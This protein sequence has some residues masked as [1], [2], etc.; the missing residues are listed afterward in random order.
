MEPPCRR[1][2]RGSGQGRVVASKHPGFKEGDMVSGPFGWQ[3]YALSDSTSMIPVQRVQ[4]F[5]SIPITANLHAMGSGGATAFVGLYDLAKPC[6]G[7][8]VLVS[9]AA[10]NVGSIVCQLAKLSGCTVVGIAGSDAKCRWLTD[11][12]G[13]DAAINYKTASVAE[14]LAAVCPNGIDIYFDNV[15]GPVLETALFLMNMKGRMVCC[16]AASQYDTEDAMGPR[17]LPG[18]LVVKRLRMEGFIYF[19]FAKHD[20]KAEQKLSTWL[21]QGKIKVVDDIVEGLENAP[22]ALIGLL[23]GENRGKRMVRVAPDPA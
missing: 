10:G 15:G 19:D 16:G 1:G 5:G 3:Q 17:N 23:A 22:R 14:Q 9:A 21:E 8:V 2:G 18:I 20:G 12:L 4:P 13:V 7:D 6:I 11:D